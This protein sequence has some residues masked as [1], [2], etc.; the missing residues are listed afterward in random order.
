[1]LSAN[2]QNSLMGQA[3]AGM[4]GYQ[5]SALGSANH[6]HAE[7]HDAIQARVS[8]K[9]SIAPWPCRT[10]QLDRAQAAQQAREYAMGR[11]GIRG[12][13]FGG[14]AEDAAMARARAEAMNN[15]SFAAMGQAQTE[16]TNQGN[17]ASQFGQLGNQASNTLNTIGYQN[18]MLG[19]NAGQNIGQL[20]IGLGQLGNQQTANADQ[21]RRHDGPDRRHARAARV[22]GVA[23]QIQTGQLTGAGYDAQLG[24][25]GIQAELEANLGAGSNYASMFCS[26]GGPSAGHRADHGWCGGGHHATGSTDFSVRFRDFKE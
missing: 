14:T 23:D 16:M 6:G 26:H 5:Q 9:S 22:I 7:R 21:R 25:G 4:G 13:Q 19:Q 18:A 15:A 11:G 24:L 8:S 12:S 1:M 10:L 2:A 3:M 20:G 17:M